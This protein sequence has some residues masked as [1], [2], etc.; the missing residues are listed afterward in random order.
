MD[1]ISKRLQTY[2]TETQEVLNEFEKNTE[3]HHIDCNET[4]SKIFERVSPI[5]ERFLQKEQK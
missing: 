1:V 3:V 5:F 4:P 2:Y